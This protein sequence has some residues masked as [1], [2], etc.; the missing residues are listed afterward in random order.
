VPGRLTKAEKEEKSARAVSL[1]ARGWTYREIAEDLGHDKNTI[2]AWIKDEY[3]RRAEH[4]DQDKEE[5][6]AVYREVI[7][8]AW[9]RFAV[10]NNASLNSSGFLNT[11][12]AAQDSINKI[13]GAEAPIKFKDMDDEVEVVWDD[14]DQASLAE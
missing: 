3:A 7:R 8:A 14:A 1:S 9:E 12:K 10:T 4:R 6:I 11:I 2:G 5:A 13:T